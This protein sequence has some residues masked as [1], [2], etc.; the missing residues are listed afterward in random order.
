MSSKRRCAHAFI[1]WLV[2]VAVVDQSLMDKVAVLVKGTALRQI[3]MDEIVE[4]CWT[5]IEK[6]ADEVRTQL[7]F[8][9]SRAGEGGEQA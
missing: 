1:A 4:R 7:D 9:R 5:H 6:I 2:D 3:C 8:S